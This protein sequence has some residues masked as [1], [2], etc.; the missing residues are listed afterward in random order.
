MLNKIA[1]DIFSTVKVKVWFN[2]A[3]KFYIY[4]LQNKKNY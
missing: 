3:E 2:R 1:H 4:K